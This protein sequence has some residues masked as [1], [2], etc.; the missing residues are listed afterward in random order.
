MIKNK[1]LLLIVV[2]MAKAAFG[3]LIY[4]DSLN[5]DNS[6]NWNATRGGWDFSDSGLSNTKKG[7]NRIFTDIQVGSDPY[8]IEFTGN[9]FSGNG[10]G[11]Y[12]GADLASDNKVTGMNFQ[13]DAGY[14]GGAYLLRKWVNDKESVVARY[15]TSLDLNS[16]HDF[17]LNISSTG[18][19]A[20]QDGIEVLK[21]SGD[22][23]LAGSMIGIRTWSAS[24]SGFSDLTVSDLTA[25]TRSAIPEP[26]TVALVAVGALGILRKRKP[27]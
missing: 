17:V 7:E 22:M 4:Q 12:F 26:A 14:G 16:D 27:L 10:W 11:F 15:Q 3:S 2:F 23:N 20:F 18:F 13:F 19:T 21:Y 6:N 9:L 5:G 25:G 24:Q 8:T 1:I